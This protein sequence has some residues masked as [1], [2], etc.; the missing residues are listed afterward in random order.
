[1]AHRAGGASCQGGRDG[2]TGAWGPRAA[3]YKRVC[4]RDN[5]S[6][7]LR[8][9]YRVCAGG[10]RAAL[11]LPPR[12]RRGG[13]RGWRA[14]GE[15]RLDGTWIHPAF[16]EIPLQRGEGGYTDPVGDHPILS[17]ARSPGRDARVGGRPFS[18]GG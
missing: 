6:A 16:G 10:E 5:L 11:G 17:A 12:E 15:V 4:R 13:Q 7:W 9:P 1:P 14:A 18:G 3:G 2:D 8:A